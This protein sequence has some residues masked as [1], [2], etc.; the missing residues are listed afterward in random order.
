MSVSKWF[1]NINVSSLFST[2]VL[3][4]LHEFKIPHNNKN[5]IKTHQIQHKTWWMTW[6]RGVLW[7][8]QTMNATVRYLNPIWLTV[9]PVTISKLSLCSPI[10]ICVCYN[11]SLTTALRESMDSGLDTY[12]AYFACSFHFRILLTENHMRYLG[13]CSHY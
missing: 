1:L 4:S 10:Y 6:E 8:G 5:Y 9:F 2:L 7:G 12:Y 3:L 11:K 13:G